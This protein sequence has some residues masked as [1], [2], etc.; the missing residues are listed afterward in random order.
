M[1]VRPKDMNSIVVHI[2]DD[3][4]CK[5][6]FSLEM[7]EDLFHTRHRCL[8]VGGHLVR[9]EG[10]E[11]DGM[12][13]YCIAGTCRNSSVKGS[14]AII[15]AY[16]IAG[17]PIWNS[18]WPAVV[19]QVP[20]TCIPRVTIPISLCLSPIQNLLLPGP[21]SITFSGPP[22]PVGA[23]PISKPKSTFSSH[24]CIWYNSFSHISSSS[25][26]H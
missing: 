5:L 20:T 9:F 2:G 25:F 7:M 24:L 16:D 26:D 15:M 12:I 13:H 3:P 11:G 8:L 18:Q 17:M 1:T 10:L 21:Q 14:W 22:A 23:V 4:M 19:M 6:E